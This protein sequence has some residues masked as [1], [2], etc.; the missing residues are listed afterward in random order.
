MPFG[1]TVLICSTLSTPRP[2]AGDSALC[3]PPVIQP[4]PGATVSDE[5]PIMVMFLSSANL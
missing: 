5:P 4:P 2:K 3:P 1:R